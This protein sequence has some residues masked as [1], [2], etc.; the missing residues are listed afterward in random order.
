MTYQQTINALND[1]QKL[2]DKRKIFNACDHR[3]EYEAI[4][5]KKRKMGV[6]D[7]AQFTDWLQGKID[8]ENT[9]EDN[10]DSLPEMNQ[11]F[12]DLIAIIDD[13][14]LTV[15]KKFN[16]IITSKLLRGINAFHCKDNGESLTVMNCNN[17]LRDNRFFGS[18]V[19]WFAVVRSAAITYGV[20]RNSR[21]TVAPKVDHAPQNYIQTV[22]D[23]IDFEALAKQTALNNGWNWGSTTV[24]DPIVTS[25]PSKTFPKRL[26]VTRKAFVPKFVLSCP[27]VR[28]RHDF[29]EY[30]TPIALVEDPIVTV[31]A[32]TARK[33]APKRAKVTR[34]LES[35]PIAVTQAEEG[36]SDESYTFKS[37]ALIVDRAVNSVIQ[38]CKP[39][40]ITYDLS[41]ENKRDSPVAKMLDS[42]G[43]DRAT[44]HEWKKLGIPKDAALAIIATYNK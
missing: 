42:M 34:V 28:I 40:I 37:I 20:Y 10:R 9:V 33:Q 41:A 38:K 26:K 23:T 7:I 31:T 21:A 24:E 32:S 19:E 22:S 39:F 5:G 29:I 3:A 36:V 44:R 27:I 8:A 35:T 2:D 12:L 25:K 13:E 43:Y 6:V 1:C 17:A 16:A 30:V 4:H 15:G 14:S 18:R 11:E